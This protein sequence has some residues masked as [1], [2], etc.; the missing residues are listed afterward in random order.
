M[1]NAF[2]RVICHL[3]D[4]GELLRLLSSDGGGE[5]GAKL[6]LE[7]VQ[8]G[9]EREQ[10]LVNLLLVISVDAGRGKGGDPGEGD[11]GEAIKDG[12]NI[13]KQIHGHGELKHKGYKAMS[14]RS[15]PI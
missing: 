6:S 2:S 4:D 9:L 15:V 11:Q 8:L 10:G 7:I 13:G 12:A 3:D 1:E 14:L 5:G